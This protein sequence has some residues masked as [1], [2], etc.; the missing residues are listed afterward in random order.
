MLNIIIELKETIINFIDT[1][2][3][4]FKNASMYGDSLLR[5][6]ESKRKKVINWVDSNEGS[7]KTKY[8]Q[9]F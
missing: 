6:L 2:K 5:E 7:N 8:N 1:N 9:Q 3:I 4:I